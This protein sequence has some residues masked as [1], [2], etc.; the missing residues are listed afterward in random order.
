[1]ETPNDQ[2][3]SK[4]TYM[5]SAFVVSPGNVKSY[6]L[7]IGVNESFN[8][9]VYLINLERKVKGL[10]RLSRQWALGLWRLGRNWHLGFTK[11]RGFIMLLSQS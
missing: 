9:W 10:G 2:L 3:L 7:S 8:R 6:Q 4:L 1:M 5:P 11:T